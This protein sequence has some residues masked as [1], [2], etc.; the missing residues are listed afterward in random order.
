[1]SAF[2]CPILI[3]LF[4]IQILV[5][6]PSAKSD[7]VIH[8]KPI[9]NTDPADETQQKI[10]FDVSN[11]VLNDL[12]RAKGI[13][14]T[15]R[16]L[17]IIP[18]EPFTGSQKL[19]VMN[20]DIG[21]IT[22]D[23]RSYLH[24]RKLG[25][26]SLNALAFI[27]GHEL[28]HFIKEHGK[29]NHNID[30]ISTP[31]SKFTAFTPLQNE[32]PP[33]FEQKLNQA[34]DQYSKT[35]HEAEADFEGA[36]LGF[37]AGYKPVQAGRDFLIA[38]YA[39]TLI[40]LNN[41]A[42][43]YPSLEERLE[44]LAKTEADLKQYI[45]YFEMANYLVALEQYEDAVPYLEK[46]LVKFQSPEIY[47]NIG[48]ILLLETIRLFPNLQT[49]YIMPL[50]LDA[51]FR[52]P[53]PQYF[54]TL[55]EEP[56]L[57]AYATEITYRKSLGQQQLEQAE[58]YFQKAFQLDEDYAVAY[59]NLSIVITYKALLCSYYGSCRSTTLRHAQG[60]AKKC[61]DIC[62]KLLEGYL[63]YNYH[64]DENRRE[65]VIF[66]A[67][68]DDLDEFIP[69]IRPFF[70]VDEDLIP[71][72]VEFIGVKVWDVIFKSNQKPINYKKWNTEDG[73][74]PIEAFALANAMIQYDIIKILN[75]E[76]DF[77]KGI[78]FNY[79]ARNTSY[80]EAFKRVLDFLPG[81]ELAIKNQKLSKNIPLVPSEAQSNANPSVE[82]YSG[83]NLDQVYSKINEWD[84]HETL[85]K[86]KIISHYISGDEIKKEDYN[87]LIQS[88]SDM[89]QNMQY[90]E[91]SNFYFYNNTSDIS[92]DRRTERSSILVPKFSSETRTTSDVSIGTYDQILDEKYGTAIREL[93]LTDG[94]MKVYRISAKSDTLDQSMI[95]ENIPEMKAEE[96]GIIFKIDTNQKI[97]S[98][99]IYKK[100]IITKTI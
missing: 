76:F 45:P 99:A 4:S 72:T 3:A 73:D 62:T 82:L 9:L 42:P 56:A 83:F 17:L 52:A 54:N 71:N 16:P 92:L 70:M 50:S 95:R 74:P 44:I 33:R 51:T 30:Q 84:I 40:N 34:L 58:T 67:E 46:I 87:V 22:L 12:K 61:I 19:A 80:R 97:T 94:T 15:E 78:E 47:N 37:L 26:D 86:S 27:L 25:K 8:S 10:M 66:D 57:M 18:K 49:K 23:F 77:E 20:L 98:W 2:I 43:G 60:I 31:L 41:T 91:M 1:M 48:V 75:Y 68:L 85:S 69:K 38:A 24:C 90:R 53:H 14:A 7:I 65:E 59:L 63:V 96:D 28:G 29:V 64:I 5:A 35:Y 55:S 79:D 100:H 81:Y 11:Q 88:K 13:L 93:Q 36:F 6:T 21:T 89:T 39:D 32:T